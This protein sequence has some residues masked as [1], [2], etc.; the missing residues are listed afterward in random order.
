[1]TALDHIN[2]IFSISFC[3]WLLNALYTT[4]R[5]RL[6]IIKRYEQETNLSKTRYFT[7]MMPWVKHIPPF[8]R[9][10]IYLSHLLKFRWYEKK[11]RF[12]TK[13]RHGK[14]EIVYYDDIKSPEQITSHFSKKE[15]KLVKRVAY[16]LLLLA[17]H[18]IALSSFKVIW[19]ERVT[20]I[21]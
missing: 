4:I 6:F 9:S 14:G 12:A 10:S 20:S 3:F 7:E 8:F 19:P 5:V 16:V 21:G 13:R 17:L 2:G 11:D 18:G 1:M 15:I